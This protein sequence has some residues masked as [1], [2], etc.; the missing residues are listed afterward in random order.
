MVALCGNLVVMVATISL[1][2]ATLNLGRKK[3][4]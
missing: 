1:F 2:V 3:R 4:A